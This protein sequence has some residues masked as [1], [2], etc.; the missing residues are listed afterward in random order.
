MVAA[1]AAMTV[2]TVRRGDP[3]AIPVAFG[4]FTAM[5]ALQGAGY[6][7]IDACGSPAN[8]VVTY[9]SLLHIVFQP[10]FINAFAIELAPRRPGRAMRTAVFTVCALS[11]AVML[12]QLYPFDWAGPCRAGAPLCG[13]QLCTLSGDWHIAWT[14][15]Y[16]GLTLPLE[17]MLGVWPGF[18][19]YMIAAFG[20]PLLYGA[21]RFVVFHALAGPVLAGMLTSNPSEAPAI[22]CLFSIGL[23]AAGL[24]PWVRARLSAPG[25]WGRPAAA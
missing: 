13:P 25:G 1:G 18:P 10:F 7:V 20:L 24:S 22:W 4:Y 5:E 11:S 15:P 3:A 2:V 21:W 8:Q 19:T 23:L 14:A 9:L 6:Q 17:A 12:L 16:N